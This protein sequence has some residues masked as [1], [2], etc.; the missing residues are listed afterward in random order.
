MR[1]YPLPG[2]ETS[3]KR[4]EITLRMGGCEG[5]SLPGFETSLKRM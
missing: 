5:I 1:A 3:L 4:M 2:F